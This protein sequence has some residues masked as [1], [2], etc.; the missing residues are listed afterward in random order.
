M[1]CEV[2]SAHTNPIANAVA[3]ASYVQPQPLSVFAYA[4]TKAFAVASA[5]AVTP[6]S[7]HAHMLPPEVLSHSMSAAAT[8]LAY[9]LTAA[10]ATF[11]IVTF[12][13]GSS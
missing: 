5:N 2:A 8:A 4:R 1:A 6:A 13:S 3:E 11:F 12:D 9:A 7:P 10:V